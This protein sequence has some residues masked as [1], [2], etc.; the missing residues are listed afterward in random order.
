[1]VIISCLAAR[2]VIIDQIAIVVGNAVIKDSDIER[3]IRVVSF[4][5]RQKLSFDLS[6]RKEAAN[7]LIDQSLI[8]REIDVG[9]YQVPPESDAD[10]LLL[11]TQKERAATAEA[12]SR[13]L[14]R[15]G[16][17]VEQLRAHLYW[18]LTVLRFIDQRFRPAVLVTEDDVQNYYREHASDFRT[19][20]GGQPK[21]LDEVR[22]EIREIITNERINRQFDAWIRAR[23]RSTNIQFLEESLK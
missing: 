16:L 2:A 3:D 21:S 8:Q 7:R 1:M 22:N 23:R 17:S 6:M 14:A 10:K 20:S 12:F 18:Q 15:Y 9:E 4:L 5:N 13:M 19:T 11:D